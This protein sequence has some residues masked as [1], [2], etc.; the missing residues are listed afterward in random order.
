[1]ATAYTTTTI[2]SVV[3]ARVRHTSDGFSVYSATMEDDSDPSAFRSSKEVVCKQF[4]GRQREYR[5]EVG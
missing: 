4:T 1:M 3:V 2:I 5:S